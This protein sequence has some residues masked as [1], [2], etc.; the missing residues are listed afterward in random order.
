MSSCRHSRSLVELL[1]FNE[2]DERSAPQIRHLEVCE[3]CRVEVGLDRVV[4][5]QLQRALQARIDG[6]APSAT[7]WA[8]VRQRAQVEGMRRPRWRLSFSF[9][10]RS[11]GAMAGVS[12]LAVLIAVSPAGVGR[13]E[14]GVERSVQSGAERARLPG[15]PVAFDGP[16]L[17]RRPEAILV[18]HPDRRWVPADDYYNEVP[19]SWRSGGQPPPDSAPEELVVAF[20]DVPL[21][22]RE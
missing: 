5:R 21:A 7:A 18:D 17:P 6:A 14:A 19:E 11:L 9:S 10:G 16:W 2:L 1:R 3:R 20:I 8:S 4:I 12:A 15:T 13:F 22:T